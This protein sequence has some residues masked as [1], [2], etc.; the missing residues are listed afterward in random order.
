M[1]T[2]DVVLAAMGGLAVGMIAGILLAP[3]KGS[4]TRRKL[5]KQGNDLKDDVVNTFDKWS[6]SVTE[7][8]DQLKAEAEDLIAQATRKY[9][10][11]K[12]KYEKVEEEV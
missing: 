11:E 9:K 2:R 10:A 1:R 3:D 8:V 6:E 4:E 7:S 12:A 5:V